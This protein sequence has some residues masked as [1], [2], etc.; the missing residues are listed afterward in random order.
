MSEKVTIKT[1]DI[2]TI[3]AASILGG[4]K[5][6]TAVNITDAAK[7]KLIEIVSTKCAEQIL[8]KVGNLPKSCSSDDTL[9]IQ[10]K[11]EL[12]ITADKLLAMVD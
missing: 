10:V 6:A 5:H 7:K 4:T 12:T 9:R 1:G 11:M 8:E 3:D 2:G